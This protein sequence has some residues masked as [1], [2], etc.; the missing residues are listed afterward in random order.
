MNPFEPGIK[1]IFKPGDKVKCTYIT[2]DR[3]KLNKIYT[4]KNII[5]DN[6]IQ[7]KEIPGDDYYPHLWARSFQLVLPYKKIIKSILNEKNI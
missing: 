4:V 5:N 1:N 6:W 2:D 7:V 3:L